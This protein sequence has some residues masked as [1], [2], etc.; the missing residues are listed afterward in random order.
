MTDHSYVLRRLEDGDEVFVVY[1]DR[2]KVHPASVVDGKH[3]ICRKCADDEG[4]PTRSG[5][6][7]AEA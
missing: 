2:C 1:C 6:G 3:L 4:P 7:N 5:P